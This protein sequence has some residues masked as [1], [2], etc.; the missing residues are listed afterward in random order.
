MDTR[1]KVSKN[2]VSS[3]NQCKDSRKQPRI[4]SKRGKFAENIIGP[5]DESIKLGVYP[6]NREVLQH[7]FYLN[8]N[9]HSKKE[10]QAKI[11]AMIRSV[12]ENSRFT[13]CARS[14]TD[15][16]LT[17]LIDN[18]NRFQQLNG[19]PSTS[20][21]KSF[22]EDFLKTLDWIFDNRSETAKSDHDSFFERK[23]PMRH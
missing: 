12:W 1:S 2:S 16:R 17:R 15:R 8:V 3:S 19:L 23:L 20:S 4:Y 21:S 11:C 13:S 10:A 18:Y 6:T 7:F 9:K 14:S 5:N 22:Q